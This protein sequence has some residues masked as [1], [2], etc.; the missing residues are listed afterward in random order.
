MMQPGRGHAAEQVQLLERAG[1]YWREE[2]YRGRGRQRCWCGS[3]DRGGSGCR[4]GGWSWS[5]HRGWCGCRDRGRPWGWCGNRNRGRGRRWGRDGNR[6][7]C[8]SLSKQALVKLTCQSCGTTGPCCA[9]VTPVCRGHAL[10]RLSHRRLRGIALKQRMGLSAYWGRD[11]R[12]RWRRW[13]GQGVHSCTAVTSEPSLS[14]QSAVE[15]PRWPV[16]AL[17]R[18]CRA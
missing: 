12:W 10:P 1:L 18:L 2:G 5:R 9:S 8:G 11:G 3:R 6:T 16:M 17:L 7:G 15:R 13:A 14:Q 4:C